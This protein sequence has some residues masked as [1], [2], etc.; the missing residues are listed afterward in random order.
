MSKLFSVAA[1]A[2]LVI[3]AFVACGKGKEVKKFA[4][5]ADFSGANIASQ[6]GAVFDRF[7]DEVIPNVNHQYFNTL[8]DL[9]T[10]VSTDKVDAISIDM[11]VAKNLV[12]AQTDL[13]LFPEVVADDKYG[14]AV[15]K[16]SE[17]G[18]KANEALK[19]LRDNGTIKGLEEIW[20]S[21][22][23][24]KKFLP[25]QTAADTAAVLRYACD[26]STIPMSYTDAEGNATGFDLDVMTRIANELGM[27]LEV[28]I[29]PMA[30]IL[31]TIVSGKADMGGNS[32]S[33]TEE[34]MKTVDFVGEYYKGGIVIVIKK[35][36]LSGK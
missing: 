15:T 24:S 18:V 23:E 34:R 28:T 6:N 27:K 16:G 26:V 19:K 8:A 25:M 30:A 32:M 10:A 17:L 7:I 14:F 4:N 3:V 22:D 20:F 2:A 35:D 33:I 5:L 13:M 1:I 36:R 12:A 29:M 31:P 11:P 21:A 9:V